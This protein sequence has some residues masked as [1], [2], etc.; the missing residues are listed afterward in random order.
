MYDLEKIHE[1]MKQQ[2]FTY[3]I[4]VN[5]HEN[6]SFLD[7]VVNETYQNIKGDKF[8]IQA[9]TGVD[10]T[11]AGKKVPFQVHGHLYNLYY[12]DGKT[13]KAEM[14]KSVPYMD[15]YVK[16]KKMV[17]IYKGIGK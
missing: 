9:Q 16:L 14:S 10:I 5:K 12:I 15:A 13:G 1:Y 8:V 11:P 6:G 7:T 17:D 2:G 3:E 4:G